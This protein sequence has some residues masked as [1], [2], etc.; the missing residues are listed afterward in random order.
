[1]KNRAALVLMEQLIVILVFILAASL[2]LLAFF[3]AHRISAETARQDMAVDLAVTG[4]EV[5]KACRGDPEQAAMVLQGETAEGM[6][7][8][9]REGLRMEIRI[10]DTRIP[11]LGGAEVRILEETTGE[12]LYS[13]T[14]NWQEV[15]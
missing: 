1:M 5:I 10:L 13:L 7:L 9:T 11:N 2:C 12:C 6:L 4:C 8:A 3:H 14:V 15:S